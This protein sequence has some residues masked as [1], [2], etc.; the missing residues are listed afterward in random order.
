MNEAARKLGRSGR[1][2][3]AEVLADP[4][5][6]TRSNRGGAW[7]SRDLPVELLERWA[8]LPEPSEPLV[9]VRGWFSLFGP[10]GFT[11]RHTHHPEADVVTVSGIFGVG[12]LRIEGKVWRE[13]NPGASRLLRAG[14]VYPLGAGETISFEGNQKHEALP[15]RYSWAALAVNWKRT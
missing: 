6:I 4:E 1:L 9:P 10:G 5:G 14:E 3:R 2:L 8:V 11:L 12:S 7:H 13:Y 15:A